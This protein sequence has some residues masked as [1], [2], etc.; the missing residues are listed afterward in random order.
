MYVLGVGRKLSS[1]KVV[2]YFNA[3]LYYTLAYRDNIYFAS[4]LVFLPKG[5]GG[6]GGVCDNVVFA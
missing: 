1:E 3:Y 2:L 4:R 6:G 5:D